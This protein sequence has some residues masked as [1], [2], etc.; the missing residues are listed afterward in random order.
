MHPVIGD[1]LDPH[2]PIGA[3]ADVQGQEGGVYALRP[4]RFQHGIVEVQACRRRRDGA[5]LACI[6]RLVTG[7]IGS[8]GRVFN[9]GR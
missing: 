4:Q 8:I 5:G 1:L 7:L 2:G 9:V 6:D 3:G